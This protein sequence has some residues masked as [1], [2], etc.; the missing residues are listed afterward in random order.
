MWSSAGGLCYFY[1]KWTEK[2]DISL[3]KKM[4]FWWSVTRQQNKYQGDFENSSYRGQA[5]LILTIQHPESNPMIP[6]TFL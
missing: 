4:S 2:Y 3:K 1:L 6:A 5:I